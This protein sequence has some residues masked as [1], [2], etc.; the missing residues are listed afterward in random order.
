MR[1]QRNMSQMKGQNKVPGKEL[2]KMETNN[3]RDAEF[4][5]F[6]IRILNELRER[7]NE[8]S[9]IFNKERENIKM[10]MTNIQGN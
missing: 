2:N 9:E 4:K 10:E 6:V 5:T 8:F 1:Q 7:V 3:L